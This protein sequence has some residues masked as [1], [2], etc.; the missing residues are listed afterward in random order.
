[1]RN[2]SAATKKKKNKRRPCPCVRAVKKIVG[3]LVLSAGLNLPGGRRDPLVANS[4]R[5]RMPRYRSRSH[6]VAVPFAA[7]K[8][9]RISRYYL[10]LTPT[11]SY[12]HSTES[13]PVMSM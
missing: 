7:S 4:S 13:R 6:A 10:S 3:A 8:K 11:I 12:I 5:P 9:R 1:M 2:K